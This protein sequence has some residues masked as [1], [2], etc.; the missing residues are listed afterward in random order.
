MRSYYWLIIVVMA[1]VLGIELEPK[2]G[3]DALKRPMKKIFGPPVGCLK[4]I[5]QSQAHL[6]PVSVTTK[7]T[8]PEIVDGCAQCCCL[9]GAWMAIKV[10]L[11]LC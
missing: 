5:S 8:A 3:P 4:K 1:N 2:Q 7:L 9:T 6:P 10:A 11:C